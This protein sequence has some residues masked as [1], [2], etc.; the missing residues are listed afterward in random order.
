MIL[1]IPLVHPIRQQEF[2]VTLWQR[3]LRIHL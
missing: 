1:L 2:P 3:Q